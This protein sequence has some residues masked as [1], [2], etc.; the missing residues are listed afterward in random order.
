MSIIQD[1]LRRKEK[2][3]AQRPARAAEP[4]PSPVAPAP[5]PPP[6]PDVRAAAGPEPYPSYAPAPPPVRPRG[7]RGLPLLLGLALVGM[8]AAAVW[9]YLGAPGAGLRLAKV[10]P[11]SSSEVVPVPA[12]EAGG[13]P[14]AASPW[15]SIR[16]ASLALAGGNSSAILNGKLI[17]VGEDIEGATLV[18]VDARGVTL[19]RD[20]ERRF[21]KMGDA[22]P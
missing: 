16:L 21:L 18:E 14:V 20:G 10:A 9:F 3:A 13:S 8:T 19:E 6:R 22:L 17:M 12:G 1:A 11:P 5:P 2:E 15:P 4:P 7:R